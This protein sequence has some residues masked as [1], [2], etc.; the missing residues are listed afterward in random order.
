MKIEQS[1]DNLTFSSLINCRQG[2]SVP[3]FTFCLELCV[4]IVNP[5]H[6]S[7]GVPDRL[8]WLLPYDS[9]GGY[10]VN[11]ALFPQP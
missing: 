9:T 5:W 4:Y 8:N 1:D 3:V 10:V 2:T 6:D 11:I 7:S